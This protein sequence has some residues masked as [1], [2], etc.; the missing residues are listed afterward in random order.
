MQSDL[1]AATTEEVVL[2]DSNGEACGTMDK[3]AVHTDNTPLHSAFSIFLFNEKQQL[4]VQQRAHTKVTWPGIWSN[5]CCGHPAPGESHEDAAARRLKEELGIENIKLTLA[6]PS[7]RYKAVFQNIMENEICPVFIG[8]CKSDTPIDFKKS[9]VESIAWVSLKEFF[10]ACQ[11]PRNTPFEDFSP[12]SIME[13]RLLSASMR[14]KQI[15][16]SIDEFSG[17]ILPLT[18]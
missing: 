5:S 3:S 18:A 8:I 2:L 12:W 15:M 11:N 4:L 6:L 9:E 7:F 16:K 17:N 1:S 13:G 14:M 10:K